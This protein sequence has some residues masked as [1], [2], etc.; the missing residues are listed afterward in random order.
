M[1]NNLFVV[2]IAGLCN[3]MRVVASAA[4][5]SRRYNKRLII[6]WIRNQKM[7]IRFSDLFEPIPHRVLEFSNEQSLSYKLCYHFIKLLRPVFMISDKD[8]DNKYQTN[9]EYFDRLEGRHG[10]L[11]TYHNVTGTNDYSMFR[12][13][14]RLTP[15]L[16]PEA[17]LHDVVGI[18]IRRTDN[19]LSIDISPTSL[20]IE[21]MEEEI[22][23][24]PA[25]RF[26]LATDSPEEESLLKEKYGDRI[27][28]YQK[29]SL[30]RG[31]K[32]GMEDAIVDLAN[33][34]HCKRIYG[35]F[36]SS[37]SYVAAQWGGISYTTIM[38]EEKVSTL[39][40]RK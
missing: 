17:S 6:L 32:A 26:Y 11:Y 39:F 27:L 23:I 19:T 34:S 2:P 38:N 10:F 20:F 12:I 1:K 5:L 31:S 40:S 16:F 25:V 24:N 3:R 36:W 9:P 8:F 29:R 35:S 30:D 7:N 37:Y 21:K 15:L 28:T 14:K 33:L 4:E 13:N 18:H 22:R